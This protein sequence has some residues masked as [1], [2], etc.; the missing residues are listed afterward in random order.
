MQGPVLTISNTVLKLEGYF[1]W[2]VK[3]INV[4]NYDKNTAKRNICAEFW[5]YIIAFVGRYVG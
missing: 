5:F 2:L 4:I 1:F 3:V